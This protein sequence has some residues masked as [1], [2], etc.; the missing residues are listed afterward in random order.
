MKEKKIHPTF[1]AVDRRDLT[2]EKHILKL[3]ARL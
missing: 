3:E 1:Q 2:F